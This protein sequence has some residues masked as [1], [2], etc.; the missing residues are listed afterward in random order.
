MNQPIEIDSTDLGDG[1][2]PLFSLIECKNWKNVE[3]TTHS[4]NCREYKLKEHSQ[5]LRDA[6][7]HL[8]ILE[9]VTGKSDIKGCADPDTPKFVE[10]VA[11]LKKWQ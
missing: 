11:E 6:V 1:T 5:M 3:K 8:D 2:V 4:V 10:A 7:V 9:I